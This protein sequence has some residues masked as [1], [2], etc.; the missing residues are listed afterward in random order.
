MATNEFKIWWNK[1]CQTGRIDPIQLGF[2]RDQ[3]TGILGEPDDYSVASKK[4]Q[5]PQILRFQKLEFHFGT[6]K[7]DPLNMIFMEDDNGIVQICIQQ[8]K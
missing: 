8:S 7:D 6:G 3:V 4:H 1:F 5:E 2:T